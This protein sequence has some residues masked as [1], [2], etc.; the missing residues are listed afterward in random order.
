MEIGKIE[1][2]RQWVSFGPRLHVLKSWSK[3][4]LATKMVN[5]IA[6]NG[7]GTRK[8]DW[9]P[10]ITAFTTKIV[11][12]AKKL[13]AWRSPPLV[14]RPCLRPDWNDLVR[15]TGD[16]RFQVSNRMR[17]IASGGSFIINYEMFI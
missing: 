1:L 15:N 4:D 7:T 10:S 9:Y 14:S 8:M 12:D 2:I 17:M 3:Q 16:A 13:K 11:K 5:A 6:A